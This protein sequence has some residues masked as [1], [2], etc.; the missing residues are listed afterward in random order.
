M[1]WYSFGYAKNCV[2]VDVQLEEPK[3]EERRRAWNVVPLAL[4]RV[5][6]KERNKRAFEE[7]ES[8]FLN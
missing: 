2:R 4:M 1:V 8:S 6:W 3:K 5:A 7:V